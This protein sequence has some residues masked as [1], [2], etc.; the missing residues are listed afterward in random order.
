MITFKKI[1]VGCDF[2]EYSKHTLEH[3]A[4]LAEKCQA[5]LIIVNIIN[6]RDVDTLLSIS[7]K[8]FDRVIEKDVKKLADDYVKEKTAKRIL[9][10]EAL[11]KEISCT[12]DS[13]KKVIRVGVP[14][15]E[16]NRVIEEE[17]VD[18]VVVGSKGRSN[19]AGILFGS[20][21]EKF[22]RHCPVPLLSVRSGKR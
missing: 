3:A 1:M 8:Q 17:Q 4:S 15:L 18:L 22:F 11:L 12:Y 19:I 7:D 5:E 20:N 10:I 9:Q 2:S 16:L 14:F 6:R 21:A 13:V